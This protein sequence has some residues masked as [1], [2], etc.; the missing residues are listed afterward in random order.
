MHMAVNPKE[1]YESTV[2]TQR[3]IAERSLD[4][5]NG[6]RPSQNRQPNW[7]EIDK[8]MNGGLKK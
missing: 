7:E 8:A 1:Q 6:T 5:H 2:D 4:T 3:S